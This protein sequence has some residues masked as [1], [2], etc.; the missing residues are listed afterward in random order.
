MKM[1]DLK[2]IDGVIY[3]M[4]IAVEGVAGFGENI[5]NRQF[6]VCE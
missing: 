2:E 3:P 4:A 6:F 1:T 5:R